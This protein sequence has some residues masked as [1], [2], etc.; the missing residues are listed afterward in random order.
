MPGSGLNLRP[1][2]AEVPLIPCATVGTLS[3]F[4]INTVGKELR[5]EKEI[6]VFKSWSSRRGA[7]VHESD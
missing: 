1:G 2:T 7:V 5:K 6:K 4:Y 3:V